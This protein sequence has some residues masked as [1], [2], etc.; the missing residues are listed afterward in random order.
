MS[1]DMS[2]HRILQILRILMKV[3][4]PSVPSQEMVFLQSIKTSQF[5]FLQITS[6]M[7]S[8]HPLYLLK[9]L[10]CGAMLCTWTAIINT[11]L[12]GIANNMHCFSGWRLL[13]ISSFLSDFSLQS[14]ALLLTHIFIF[15]QTVPR[16]A[17]LR[18]SLVLY[19]CPYKNVCP[20][21]G[22][23][24]CNFVWVIM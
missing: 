20:Y 10:I 12:R 18:S 8:S 2:Q 23:S 6:D 1:L 19:C 9:Y 15:V 3:F 5:K 21:S 14:L 16:K 7:T 13:A 4:H 22:I 24:V 17:S 11:R